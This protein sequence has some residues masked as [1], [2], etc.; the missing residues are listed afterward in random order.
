[1][2]ARAERAS[3][4]Y[5]RVEGAI[6]EGI[7]RGTYPVGSLL[8]TEREICL[9]F[10]VS[11]IT[12]RRALSNLVFKGLI[13][14]QAGLGTQVVSTHS[15]IRLGVALVGFDA[16]DW[17]TRGE[18][19]GSLVSGIGDSAWL[20]HADFVTARLSTNDQLALWLDEGVNGLDGV[21]LRVAGD[22]TPD[23]V[24]LLAAR[25]MP[26]VAVKRRMP[27]VP[28][29]FVTH[30]DENAVRIAIRHLFDLG[31][32]RVGIVIQQPNISTRRDQ[33]A[34]YLQGHD[35]AGVQTADELVRIIHSDRLATA[36]DS[37]DAILALLNLK[38]RPTAVIVAGSV[39]ATGVYSAV[40]GSGLRIPEDLSVIGIGAVYHA[41]SFLP[42][43]TAVP[44]SY[45]ELGRCATEVLIKLV[46]G[47]TE[48]P[49]EVYV[50]VS[51]VVRSSTGPVP[52]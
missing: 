4:L 40:H 43:L 42:P 16:E 35:E 47:E 52:K 37:S 41:D 25:G 8:P 44:T 27:G 18:Y 28:I 19:F 10:G 11:N 49:Q 46:S 30:D 6:E 14:R 1:M 7:Q 33:L 22:V 9:S 48:A 45:Q 5:A 20:S 3:H 15:R 24:A 38:R 32:R 2:M 36:D 21:L 34:G 51:L 29:N 31:H 12:V 26:W 23:H 50:P 39:M 13:V 17:T